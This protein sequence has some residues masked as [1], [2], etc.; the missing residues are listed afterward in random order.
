MTDF[1]S[2]YSR[3]HCYQG[4][5]TVSHREDLQSLTESDSQSVALWI[6]QPTCSVRETTLSWT[7]SVLKQIELKK[8]LLHR[9]KMGTRSSFLFSASHY[10]T[11]FHPS[12]FKR[13]INTKT[14]LFWTNNG[15][16][17][18][19]IAVTVWRMTWLLVM[20][21]GNRRTINQRCYRTFML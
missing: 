19:I 17:C 9:L 5:P 1:V 7:C 20:Y 8:Y 4:T 18:Y 15:A 21:G 10:Y 14:N 11:F 2:W 13:K 16:V 3:L 6:H 12:K